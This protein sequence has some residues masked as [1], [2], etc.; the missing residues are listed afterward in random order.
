MIY[1]PRCAAE[2]NDNV[3]YC[4]SCGLS[5]EF[6]RAYIASEGIKVPTPR[7]GTGAILSPLQRLILT[8]VI[9]VSPTI[10]LAV[11]FALLGEQFHTLGDSTKQVFLTL[12]V[13]SE[14]FALPV[15]IWGI[16]KYVAQKR[17]MQPRTRS[18]ASAPEPFLSSE[19]VN[20]DRLLKSPTTNPLTIEAPAHSSVTEEETQQLAVPRG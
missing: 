5:V 3:K 17:S 4:K 12:L 16:F 2:T 10:A 7:S 11:C 15:I 19:T 9:S 6:L 8:L 13:V 18:A 14:V 20:S 1:C